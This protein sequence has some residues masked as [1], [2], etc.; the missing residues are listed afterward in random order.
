MVFLSWFNTCNFELYKQYIFGIEFVR[1]SFVTISASK[2]YFSLTF[3]YKFLNL[4]LGKC[5]WPFI[6]IHLLLGRYYQNEEPN[7]STVR[8]S[9]MIIAQEDRLCTA[10]DVFRLK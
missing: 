2:Q 7:I 5:R 8:D 1:G 6:N 9:N 10:G 4:S 3:D